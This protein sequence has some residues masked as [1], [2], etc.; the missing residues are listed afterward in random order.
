MRLYNYKALMAGQLLEKAQL[1]LQGQLLPL[2]TYKWWHHPPVGRKLRWDIGLQTDPSPSILRHQL[3]VSAPPTSIPPTG[4]I[5]KRLWGG[6]KKR[7]K[8]ETCSLAL[9]PSPLPTQLPF[10]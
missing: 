10:K 5:C 3:P 9:L 1:K 7:V 2:N 8:G 4:C 6:G